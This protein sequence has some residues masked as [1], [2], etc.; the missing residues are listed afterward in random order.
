MLLMIEFGEA[1]KIWGGIV[2]TSRT[3]IITVRDSF[4]LHNPENKKD[5]KEILKMITN[6]HIAW[7]TALRYAMRTKKTW[8]A[9][10]EKLSK[11]RS[12]SV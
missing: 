9:S 11:K 6:R 7:L 10:Y 8:E 4:Y 12:L 5:E 2:N 1:R 3:L